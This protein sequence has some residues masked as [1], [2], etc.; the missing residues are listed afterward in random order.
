[1]LNKQSRISNAHYYYYYPQ[2]FCYGKIEEN[3]ANGQETYGRLLE[4]HAIS[5]SISAI[6]DVQ[7][8]DLSLKILP[9][10]A[11]LL[12]ITFENACNG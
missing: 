4:N 3:M 1:L 5:T 11:Q 2:R 10:A 7:R 12:K 8:N 6:A 9:N